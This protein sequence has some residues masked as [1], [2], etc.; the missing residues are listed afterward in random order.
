MTTEQ[1]VSQLIPA[2]RAPTSTPGAAAQPPPA[3]LPP[4]RETRP[5]RLGGQ[6]ARA[7]INDVS[8]LPFGSTLFVVPPPDI[9]S[10]WRV[11][12]LDSY[13]L[14]RMAPARL[15]E[16][17]ADLSPEVSR[18][19]WDFARMFNPG[20]E[21]Q[22]LRPS[23][24]VDGRGQA[25]LDAFWKMMGELYI[26]PDVVLNAMIVAGFL[27]GA[28][29]AEMVLDDAGRLPV[30]LATPDPYSFRFRKVT[31]P[32]RGTVYQ[33]GQMQGGKFVPL[34]APTI[35]YVPIDRFPTSP[36]GRSPALPALF[37]AIFL[38]G[39]LHDLRRVVQQQGYPRLDLEVVMET[40]R[41]AIPGDL[42]DD[43][44][45]FKEWVDATIG[46]ISD[47]YAS[48]EPDD[49]YVH[50]DV[51]KVNRPVGTVDAGS[52]GAVD[53]LIA[54]LERMITRAL[55][56]MPLLMGLSDNAGETFANRQWELHVAGI[57]AI[58]HLLES[59]LERLLT[60]MLQAQGI[61]AAVEFRFAELRASEELRDQQTLT[62]KIT[63]L[64]SMY[65][66][67][68]I[69]QEEAAMEATGHEPDEEEPRSQP[70]AQPAIVQ[71][72]GDGQPAADDES[73]I[74]KGYW[75]QLYKIQRT[76]ETIASK[77]TETRGH[78]GNG[79]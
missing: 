47:V 56:T 7:S 79:H 75:Q 45:K 38:L 2:P 50:T 32:V 54:G 19:L 60:V 30:D 15:I 14:S 46:E 61:Q 63:N 70:Q 35:A 71:D 69:S 58:Q 5:P 12:E 51:V 52:L 20:W 57:K 39:M 66:Q 29:A 31:D 67:G 25:A 1:A 59:L 53:G 49:A 9:E 24:R 72:N 43:P 11:E 8:D 55:K 37:A 40:L 27:R 73:R 44:G 65:D 10:Q 64:I 78:N 6:R 74:L 68:W 21:C 23:G 62:M 3:Q 41:E 76:I 42:E 22:A 28:F 48:L 18:A 13:T 36:Y 17:L 4:H 16:L 33:L 34:D 77:V 26:S